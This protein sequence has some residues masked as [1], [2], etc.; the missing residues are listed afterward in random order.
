MSNAVPQD[1]IRSS[2]IAVLARDNHG[3]GLASYLAAMAC[4][5]ARHPCQ[6]L[7]RETLAARLCE[8][9]EGTRAIDALIVKLRKKPE[10]DPRQPSV[11]LSVRRIGYMLIDQ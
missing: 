1:S 3:R 5:L 8:R 7:S 10:V 11:I 9:P 6:V 4:E 2:H